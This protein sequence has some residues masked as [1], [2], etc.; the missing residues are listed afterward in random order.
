MPRP[1]LSA[2]L[3]ALLLAS[4]ALVACG[5]DLPPSSQ[6]GVTRYE[7]D[8]RQPM[9]PVSGLTLTGET[10]DLADLRGR[11]VVLNSWASWCVPCRDEVPAFVDLAASAEPDGVSVVGLNVS[12]DPTAAAAFSGELGMQYPSIVDADGAILPTIPGVP[13]AALPSTVIVDREGRMAATVIGVV[14]AAELADLV[15]SVA[16]EGAAP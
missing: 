16:A 15:A 14:D 13:P 8:A 1:R 10:L 9:P 6:V 7:P 2:V 11:V 5:R 3:A 12:D 4:V